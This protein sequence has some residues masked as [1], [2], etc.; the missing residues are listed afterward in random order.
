MKVELCDIILILRADGSKLGLKTRVI[1]LTE[2]VNALA[3]IPPQLWYTV[4]LFFFQTK[5]AVE[6]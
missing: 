3:S 6:P 2:L 5:A 4:S 1:N